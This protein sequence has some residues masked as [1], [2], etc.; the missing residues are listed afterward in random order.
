MA[1]TVEI[2]AGSGTVI[3][4]DDVTGVH[5]QRVKLVDGTLDSTTAIKAGGGAE[6]GALLVTLANDS[7]GLVSVDDNAGSLTVDA[8]VATPVFVRLSDGAAAITTLPVS[9]ASVPSHAV[10]NAGTFATQVDGSALTALQLIDD[11]VFVDDAAFTVGTSKVMATGIQAVAHS[12]PDAADALDAVIPIA[13]VHR[14][15]FMIGGHPL[16]VTSGMRTT[17][18]TADTALLPGTIGAGNRIVITRLSVNISNACTVNVGVKIGFGTAA[19]PADNTT[20]VADVLIDNDAFPP[21]GGVNVG[22]GSGMI[23]IGA[24]GAELRITS[25]TPT[26]GSLHVS[27]TY[28]IVPS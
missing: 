25:D 7:T 1:D 8:P 27:Y 28:Y 13:N 14:V 24:D 23:G 18:S 2:T 19:V 20:G 22:D 6:A 4:T 11:P 26:G 10:T 3:A 12:A 15:P 9:L 21:G 5:Y 16:V 17:A